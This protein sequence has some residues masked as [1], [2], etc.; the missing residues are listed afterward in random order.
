LAEQLSPLTL[1][2]LSLEHGTRLWL[3]APEGA[4]P[5]SGDGL[6]PR[7][8]AALLN[9][10]GRAVAFTTADCL[11]LLVTCQTTAGQPA[12]LAIHAGWRSLAGGIIE[13]ALAALAAAANCQLADFSAWLGPAIDQQHYEVD[14]PVYQ[15]LLSRPAVAALQAD[16]LQPSRPGHW[17]ADLVGCAVAVLLDCGLPAESLQISGLSTFN[18]LDLHSA[19]RDGEPA[20]RMATFVA[21]R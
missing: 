5:A 19:R 16:L 11:P 18:E 12:A 14:A 4:D 9:R 20:G 2:W 13:M 7:A 8:D 6:C 21:I 15:G 3:D 1:T 17:L 10:P